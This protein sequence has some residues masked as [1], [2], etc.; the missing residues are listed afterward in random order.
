MVSKKII[1]LSLALGAFL[2]FN[3]NALGQD[4]FYR[5]KV[6]RIIVGFPP[7]GGYDTYSRLIARQL[8]RHIPGNP[9]IVVENMSGASSLIAAN[10]MYRAARPDGLT[11][12]HFIGGLFLQQLLGKPGIEFDARKFEFIGAPAQDNFI[13]GLARA[14]G[15]TSA[16][17][18]LASKT[19]IKFG[20]AGFGAGTD[21][22]PVVARE[23][24]GLPI[25]LVS[26]YKGTA[27]I[28]LAFNNGEIQGITNSWQSVRATW[29]NELDTGQLQ[30]I[31]QVAAKSHPELTKY[32]LPGDLVKTAEGKKILQAVT[33]V[34]GASVR[35]YVLPPNTP[36]DRVQILRK[37]FQDTMKDSELLAEAER[38]KIEINPVN[39][40]DLAKIVLA[41]MQ[42]EPGLVAKLKEVIR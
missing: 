10:H 31:M 2:G 5:D 14:T 26:G 12:G 22:I 35:P 34:H 36:K 32:P 17:Q 42:L 18:W 41:V 23:V 11:I 7:G 30:I 25:Q 1:W 16:Q 40:E 39:G 13:I 4:P 33:Q 27:D 15:I 24:M 20:G 19:V 6:L 28:R 37:A 21:D 9:T 3:S 38:G 8:G 29:R